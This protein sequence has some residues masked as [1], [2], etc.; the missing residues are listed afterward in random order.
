MHLFWLEKSSRSGFNEYT[1]NKN[2]SVAKR[3]AAIVIE[4]KMIENYKLI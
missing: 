4:F 2:Y 3:G 1:K